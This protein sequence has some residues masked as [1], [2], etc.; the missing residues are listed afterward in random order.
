MGGVTS[1]PHNVFSKMEKVGDLVQKIRMN[2]ITYA[3]KLK[4]T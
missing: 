4:M 2:K 1:I 3:K